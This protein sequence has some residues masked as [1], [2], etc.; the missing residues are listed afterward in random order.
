MT[1]ERIWREAIRG[2]SLGEML[3]F[4]GLEKDGPA[5]KMQR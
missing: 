3:E 5:K 4:R 1:R 2:P